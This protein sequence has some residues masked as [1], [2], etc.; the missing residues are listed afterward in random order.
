MALTLRQA[1]EAF[2]R[3]GEQVPVVIGS[4]LDKLALAAHRLAV[5]QF[6]QGLGNGDQ[7]QA[8]GQLK[9]RQPNPPPGPIGIRS[10]RLRRALGR[11]KAHKEGESWVTGLTIDT[12][13]APYGAIQEFGGQTRA[14][15]IEPRAVTFLRWRGTGPS[16][17]GSQAGYRVTPD[18]IV[19]GKKIKAGNFGGFDIFSRGVNHPGSKIP[20][21]PFAT[22][23]VKL[24]T[25]QHLPLLE[26]DLKALEDRILGGRA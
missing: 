15:R 11:I 1:A 3:Y 16:A 9:W 5:T 12:G 17:R 19:P 13:A 8:A 22:P 23:A 14:H 26:A 18:G 10:G 2:R 6:M 21:R 4:R 20:A 25:E 24:A 7:F